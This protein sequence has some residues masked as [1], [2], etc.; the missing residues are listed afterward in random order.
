[1]TVHTAPYKFET[2]TDPEIVTF[3]HLNNSEAWKGLLT[4]QEYAERE[5]ILGNSEIGQK[6]KLYES[7]KKF[8]DSYQWLGL[9]YFTLK[10]ERLPSSDKF[11]QIVSSCETLNRVGYCITPGSNGKIEPALVVCIGGVFTLQKHRSKGYAKVMIE[12]LNKFY[13]NLRNE[14]KDDLLIKNLVVNLYSEVDDYYEQFGYHSMHVPLHYVTEL[15]KMF[16]EYCGGN[17][18]LKGTF[19]GFD[20]YDHLIRLH[21][22][23]F[24]KR[25]LKLHRE[26]PNSY[27]FTVK[28]D[29]DI[30]K[31]FQ[32]RDIFIMRATGKGDTIPPFGFALEDKSHIIWHHNW[33]DNY[34]VITKVFFAS[35]SSKEETLKKLIAHAITEAKAKGLSKLQ[36]WD[37][38]IPIK[39]FSEL[40]TLMH[41]LEDKSKLYVSNS[42]VSAVRPP[43]GYDKNSV[44]W[45]N[46]TKFCWF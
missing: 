15:D 25:L 14:Y 10:D 35:E 2:Y 26:H 36:F 23:D 21:D 27:I 34:L 11:S 32:H 37:E 6:H 12:S 4:E 20:D 13:E 19:L 9:K 46:N 8:P 33:N 18:D 39:R 29:L 17:L 1:M 40:D 31:W 24:K 44:I 5:K 7:K 22:E 45:D 30:Y 41:E 38:E 16:S 3:T 43:N 42:S 28:P